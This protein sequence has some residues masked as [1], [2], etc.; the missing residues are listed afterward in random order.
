M[1]WRSGHRTLTR[2]LGLPAPTSHYTVHRG[3]RIPMRDGVDLLADHYEPTGTAKGTLLVRGPYGRG[4]PFSLLYTRVYAAHG[5]HVVLQSVRGTADSGGEFQ[6]LVHET[7]DGVDTVEWLRRQPW[8]TGRFATIGQSYLGSTQWALLMDPPPELAAA[9][10]TAGPHDFATSL[11]DTGAFRLSD[12]LGWCDVMAHQ[13]HGS[14]LKGLLWAAQARRRLARATAAL[15]LGE[16]A[17][18]ML[19]EGASW[20]DSWLEHHDPDHPYWEP[21]RFGAALDRAKVPVLL[22]GGW[23]DTFLRQTV[24]QYQRLRDRGADAALTVG[25][26]THA[27]LTTTGAGR[28]ARESLEWLDRHL[29]GEQDSARNPVRVWI[30]GDWVE[31]ADWPPPTSQR[32][33]HLAPGGAL[34]EDLPPDSG[35]ASSF[36]YD[37][38]QPTSTIGGPL[39]L[40]PK[41]GYQDD[42]AMAERHDVLSFTSNPLPSTLYVI[43]NPVVEIAHAA[44][45]PHVDLFVRIS[46]V[47]DRGRSR[48]VT[49]SYRRLTATSEPGPVRI[50]LDPTAH[51]FHAGSRIRLLVAG[52]AHPLFGRNAGTGEPTITA[53]RLVPATHTVHHGAG[54]TSRLILPTTATRPSPLMRRY[55]S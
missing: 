49:E 36:T 1:A 4:I 51:R 41:S 44:D 54:G 6:P 55:Q 27:Q 5:Y 21:L 45:I 33:L 37:P 9:V 30:S 7:S 15:P 17:R 13:E 40:A 43:G 2:L 42:T 35:G 32:V 52:G 53:Q 8:F 24:E 25:P 14:R 48:N 39:L 34:T 38:A 11:W 16:S 23:Q 12:S 31:L 3:L 50:E 26:W 46:E 19:G 18:A 22:I 10:I 29:A 28:A 47:D 20:F